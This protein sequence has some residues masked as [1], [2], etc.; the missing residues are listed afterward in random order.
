[1]AVSG[2]KALDLGNPLS[3]ESSL[4]QVWKTCSESCGKHIFLNLYETQE[5]AGWEDGMRKGQAERK[6]Q[7]RHFKREVGRKAT[8]KEMR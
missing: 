5:N 7:K 3:S 2:E 6:K 4:I 1:M 8:K